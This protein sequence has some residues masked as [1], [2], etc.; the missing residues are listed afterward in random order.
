MTP[1]LSDQTLHI[2]TKTKNN[3]SK[4][5]TN[6]NTWP[7]LQLKIYGMNFQYSPNSQNALVTKSTVGILIDHKTKCK[8]KSGFTLLAMY[9]PKNKKSGK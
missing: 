4:Y 3:L 2:K 5:T 7:A 1:L 8:K 9:R 6:M